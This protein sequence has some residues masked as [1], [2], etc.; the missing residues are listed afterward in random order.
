MR[1]YGS[2]IQLSPPDRSPYICTH[3]NR[4]PAQTQVTP[5]QD[6]GIHVPSTVDGKK[7]IREAKRKEEKI[8]G[9]EERKQRSRFLLRK[10]RGLASRPGMDLGAATCNY[11][12][13]SSRLSFRNLQ[14]T[15]DATHTAP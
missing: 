9:K 14:P 6:A 3:S 5:S 7:P 11:G 10:G 13:G 2:K 15:L 4:I 8:G 1:Q 12:E